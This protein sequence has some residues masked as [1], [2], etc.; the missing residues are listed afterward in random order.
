MKILM[1]VYDN[2]SYVSWFPQGLAYL[3]SA[4]RNAGHEVD[5]YQQ[6]IYH[7]EDEKLT[8]YLD[9]N[10]YD[11]VEIS[12][13]GGYYQ[14]RKLLSL[15]KAINLS[16]RRNRFK[17]TIGGHGPAADPEYFLRV[18]G[19]DIVGIGE[20]EITFVEMMDAFDG[21]RSLESVDGIAFYNEKGEYVRTRARELIK[22]IDEIAWPAYDLFDISHYS[23]LRMPNIKS[24]ERCMPML[25]GR[26][27]VFACNFCYRLDKGFRPRSAESIIEEMRF[28]RDKY[29]IR[30][31]SFSDELLM[32]SKKRTMDLCESFI[33]ANLDMR[34]DCNGRLNFAEKEVLEKMKEAGCV[35]IN[36][37]IE[38]LDDATLE[39]MHKHLTKEQIVKGVEAT[40]EVGISPGLN[41]IFGNINEPIS[42]LDDAVEFLLKYDDHAQLRTIRPVTPYP[43]S[44][45]FN[46]AIEK[47]LIK[48][49]EDF[50]ENKHIN[51]D[52]IAVNFTEYSDEEVYEALFKA[53]TK[54]INRY[55]QVVHKQSMETCK[56]LYMDRDAS[57]RGFRAV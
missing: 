33:S 18:T 14:Y 54:L 28:L 6:D 7:W 45:L 43:G 16:K 29:N 38:S 5:I 20:G 42:A 56:K 34:W 27:C 12:I 51:S 31:I 39:V 52:L 44:E 24:V 23:L 13:I 55:Q 4:A 30:Y 53:N 22:N 40:L 50:Y 36:Y 1:V 32:S 19:A 41:I 49:T 21:K 57:F 10:D 47:G 48:D 35:F 15:S 25:S 2:G 17:S 8:E 37:G 26:G 3:S 46:Y 11:V 9:S